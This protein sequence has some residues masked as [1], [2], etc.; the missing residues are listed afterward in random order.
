MSRLGS[1]QSR[2]RRRGTGTPCRVRG[3]G[4]GIPEGPREL[5]LFLLFV[6]L[7]NILILIYSTTTFR[8]KLQNI[9]AFQNYRF[10]Y[11]SRHNI[12]LSV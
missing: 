10:N 7:A 3:W 6:L 2:Q 9:L 12:Y 4:S 8:F 1:K 11:V 5:D